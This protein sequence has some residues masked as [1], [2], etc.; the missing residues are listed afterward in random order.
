[1][2]LANHYLVFYDEDRRAI[3]WMVEDSYW[4][5]YLYDGTPVA[6]AV[7]NA[8]YSYPG[9]Y[10]GCIEDGWVWDRYGRA[11]MYTNEAEEAADM[12]THTLPPPR[13]ARKARPPLGPREA[14][15]PPVERESVWAV[16]SGEA[17]FR[18]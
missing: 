1:M 15:P 10:L 4:S 17:F 11:V 14:R 6:W 18:R 3:A 12:A 8:I 2:A 13:A 9:R 5:I 16:E 7:D